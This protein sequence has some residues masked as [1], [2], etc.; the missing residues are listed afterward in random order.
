M[1]RITETKN[2]E[3][4]EVLVEGT[5]AEAEVEAVTKIEDKEEEER[6]EAVLRNL[7]LI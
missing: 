7:V 2:E 3:E 4:A 5:T 1:K 6:V